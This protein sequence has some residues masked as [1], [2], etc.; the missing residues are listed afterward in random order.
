MPCLWMTTLEPPRGGGSDGYASSCAMNGHPS[1]WSCPRR[2]TTPQGGQRKDRTRG[3]EYATHFT[4]KFRKTPSPQAAA[5]E[6]HRLTDEEGGELVVGARPTPLVE[7]RP[8]GKVER[9]GGIGYEHV[10]ALDA[11]VLRMVE[12]VDDVLL[13]PL[14][15][16]EQA[17]VLEIP[18]VP[19]PSSVV[20]AVQPT[21]FEQVLNAQ[22]CTW[23]T[24]TTCS[25]SLWS[26]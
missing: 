15:L 22:C 14:V 13:A 9:H 3:G 24:R 6:Y 16:Q 21:D 1:P 5:T 17:I 11:P 12:E 26:S 4:A 2:S 10:L 18:E 19:R 25:P 23:T 7:R 20:R 8:Q